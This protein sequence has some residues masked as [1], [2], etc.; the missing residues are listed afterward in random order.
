MCWFSSGSKPQRRVVQRFRPAAGV[1]NPGLNHQRIIITYVQPELNYV[2]PELQAVAEPA[3][4]AAD[5]HKKTARCFAKPLYGLTPVPRVRIPLFP[6]GL[7]ARF[8]NL[9]LPS[10][11]PD[12][13]S[14]EAHP[15]HISRDWRRSEPQHLEGVKQ[16]D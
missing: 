13:H 11:D 16:S 1:I 6:P 7:S 3:G 9:D 4:L 5:G 8:S 14:L 12:Q 15:V 2:Q 10:L